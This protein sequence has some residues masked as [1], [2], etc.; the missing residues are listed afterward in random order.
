MSR[1][2]LRTDGGSRGNPGPAGVGFVIMV[3]GETVCRAGAY[4]GIAT[5]NV[6]EYTALVWGLENLMAL[7]HRSVEVEADSELVVKQL[8]GAY[9]VKNPGLK[10][11]FRR[12]MDLLGSLDGFTVRHI[13]RELNAEADALANE[14]MDMRTTVGDPVRPYE[15]RSEGTLF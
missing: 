7:G 9:K 10:P 1:V 2:I 5:N 6:A 13:R 11:L 14:A 4:V 8:L 12:V 15:S 3:D